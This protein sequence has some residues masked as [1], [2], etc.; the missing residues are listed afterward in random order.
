M[1]T[2]DF[3][4]GQLQGELDALE[5]RGRDWH[6]NRGLV[7]YMVGAGAL[8]AFGGVIAGNA[9]IGTFGATVGIIAAI[10]GSLYV[11]DRNRKDRDEARRANQIRARIASTN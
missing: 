1:A 6:A 2:D 7:W 10:G 9:E 4:R 3:T 5:K 11:Y 8:A